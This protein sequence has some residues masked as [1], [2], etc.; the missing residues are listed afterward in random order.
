MK[1]LIYH[2]ESVSV[3]KK[4]ALKEY[5]MNR[6]RI[7][8]IRR[9]ANFIQRWFFYFFFILIVVPRNVIFYIKDGD[10]NFIKMLFKAIWWNLTNKS[11]STYLGHALK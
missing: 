8:F 3:G 6:N 11:N 4:S 1:A 9:N 7:L 5:F 2:K 10:T